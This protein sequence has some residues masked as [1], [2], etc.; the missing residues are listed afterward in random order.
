MVFV[1]YIF[2]NLSQVWFQNARAKWRR[3]NMKQQ[4]SMTG[5]MIT[6]DQP[7]TPQLHQ[8][9]GHLGQGM[10]SPG[11]S[12]SEHSPVHS[13]GGPP[14]DGSLSTQVPGGP[15]DFDSSNPM[16]PLVNHYGLNPVHNG[17]PDMRITSFHELF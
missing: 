12:Y 16:T 5:G 14:S 13:C 1:K 8:S 11:S 3:N 10:C 17:E 7:S 4:D 2:L 6:G 15:M 9:G